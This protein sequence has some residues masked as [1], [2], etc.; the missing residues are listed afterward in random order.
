MVNLTPLKC[1]AIDLK[2]KFVKPR[3]AQPATHFSMV[4]LLA[5]DHTFVVLRTILYK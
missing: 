4:E 3:N 5:V 2:A 1:C